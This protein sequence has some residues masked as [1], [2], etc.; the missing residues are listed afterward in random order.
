MGPGLV[1][2][3]ARML[4]QPHSGLITDVDG[5]LSPIV[6]VPE[7]ARVDPRARAA[8]DGLKPYLDLVAVVSGR[9]VADARRLV[10][11]DGLIY[12]GNH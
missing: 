4:G 3:L 12:I 9:S 10:D 2:R 6:A 1:E 11:I 7:A 5:T 8:L